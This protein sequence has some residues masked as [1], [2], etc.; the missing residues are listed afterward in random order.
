M[1]ERK[2]VELLVNFLNILSVNFASLIPH[3]LFDLCPFSQIDLNPIFFD[4]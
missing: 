4:F 1:G 2:T 3:F